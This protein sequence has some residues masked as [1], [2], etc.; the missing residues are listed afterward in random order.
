MVR[1]KNAEL[2]DL[3]ETAA[4]EAQ[5]LLTNAKRA[6][7]VAR[8]KAAELAAV[9]QKDAVGG[10]AAGPPRPGGERPDRARWRPPGRSPTRPGSGW[11]G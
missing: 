7:R 8:K 2:A 10:P 5:R 1:R 9:G 11:P 3:A 4:R 6:L